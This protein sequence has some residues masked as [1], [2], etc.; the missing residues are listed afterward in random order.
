MYPNEAELLEQL[1][2]PKDVT[3]KIFIGGMVSHDNCHGANMSLHSS[4]VV[5]RSLTVDVFG[6]DA[7]RIVACEAGEGGRKVIAL[8]L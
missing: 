7:L 8:I 3:V 1:P 6:V 4:V 5:P 2:V